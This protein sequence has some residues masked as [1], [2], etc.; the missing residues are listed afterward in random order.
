MN[1]LKNIR[2]NLLKENATVKH[3]ELIEIDPS[4]EHRS[5]G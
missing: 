3:N 5:Q 4:K 2:L 1:D